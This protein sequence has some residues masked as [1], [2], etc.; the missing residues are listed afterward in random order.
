M[1]KTGH[2]ALGDTRLKRGSPL[3]EL[4]FEPKTPGNPGSGW[5]RAG[6]PWP[7]GR[8]RRD[9]ESPEPP[10]RARAAG[11]EGRGNRALLVPALALVRR[12]HSSVASIEARA[13]SA[14]N[15]GAVAK[16]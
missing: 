12:A 2:H 6:T 16:W 7:G 3:T 10:A 5:T 11:R 9:L 4:G 14:P 15:A 13:A 1:M 8:G